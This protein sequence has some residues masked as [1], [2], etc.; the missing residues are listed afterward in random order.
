M[1]HGSAE[2]PAGKSAET[3]QPR[4]DYCMRYTK[5]PWVGILLGSTIGGLVPAIWGAGVVS[6]G[7]ITFS[8]VGAFIGLYITFK[9]RH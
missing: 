7:G 1:Y 6:L 9:I 5:A 3:Q 2:L 8:V 4:Y